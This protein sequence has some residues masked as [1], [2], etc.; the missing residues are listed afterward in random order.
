MVKTPTAENIRQIVRALAELPGG[1]GTCRDLQLKFEEIAH[2]KGST[3]FACL[4]VARSKGWVIREGKLYILDPAGSY[5]E[6]PPSIEA[7][8]ETA[9]RNQNRLEVLV[10]SREEQLQELR[11]KVQNLSDW[12]GGS[13]G[14]TAVVHLIKILADNDN[15]VTMRQKLKAAEVVLNYK[16]DSDVRE[17][18]RAYLES[19]V[20]NADA[21]V[22]YRILAGELLRKCEGAPRIMSPIE[23]PDAS[24][25][26]VVDPEKEEEE[27]RIEFLRKKEHCDRLAAEIIREL[28]PPQPTHRHD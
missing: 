8:L 10:G 21:L 17:F 5:R 7:Q 27:R 20:E 25:P 22:D 23:R 15:T 3:F 19:V 12:A 14:S 4:A 13:N 28:G 26:R 6:T 11:D 9:E 16:V 18:A 1:T 2:R 24:P